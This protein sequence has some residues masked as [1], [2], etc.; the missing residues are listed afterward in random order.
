M[1]LNFELLQFFAYKKVIKRRQINEILSECER[2]KMPAEKYLIAKDYCTEI[3]ALAAM[4]EFYSMPYIE[5]PMLEIDE[6]LVDN[7]SLPFL[8]KQKIVPVSLDNDGIMLVAVARPLDFNALSSIAT[9]YSGKIEFILVP[10]VQIDIYVDSVVAVKYTEDALD[11]LNKDKDKRLISKAM[12]DQDFKIETESD[13]INAP[14]VKFVDSV[15]KEAIPFRASD[16]HIEPFERNV[17]VRYRIDGE[18]SERAVFPLESYPAIAARIKIVS[19]MSISER[20]LPQDGRINLVING[21]EYDFRVSSFPT[22][23]G[24]KIVIRI[25]DKSAFSFSRT[26][27]GFTDEGNAVIDK[28][29]AHPHGIVLLSGPTGCGKSTTLYS[30]LRELNKPNVNIITVEDPVEYTLEGINQS[31][32]NKKANLTFATAL[33]S[34]LRQDP[35]II[36]IGEIRDE[37]TAQIAIRAA[38]TG[39]LVF[40]TI[41]TNDAPGAL[42]RLVD[43]GVTNYLV[44][45]ALVGVISQRLVKRLCPACKKKRRTNAREMAILGLDKPVSIYRPQGCQFCNQ[46]GYRGR[47]AVH[48]IMYLNDKIRDAMVKG[49]SAEEIREVAKKN[50][51]ISLW[52]V[53][54]TYVLQGITSIEELMGLYME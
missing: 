19:G 25:L 28:I 2:L 21:T 32:V 51:M 49:M 20:R 36:M 45:D 44:A 5:L 37:E 50:G 52:N 46:T 53:G 16:I 10:G 40:S 22:V 13:V 27:L 35:D 30:F 15:I 23:Y 39:H 8:K 31:Q 38:I 47:T 9:F 34:I 11:N 1:N 17:K 33:R 6:S 48:E 18:L 41:H 24:E 43:M 54:K 14:A 12:G 3:T 29:L 4:G 26:K 7:F 42:T